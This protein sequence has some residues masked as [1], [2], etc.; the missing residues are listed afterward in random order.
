M[1]ASGTGNVIDSVEGEKNAVPA[2]A[3]VRADRAH[4]DVGICDTLHRR[5]RSDGRPLRQIVAFCDVKHGED[6]EEAN[7]P[8]ALVSCDAFTVRK[9]AQSA[10]IYSRRERALFF[11]IAARLL[12][13]VDEVHAS[14]SPVDLSLHARHR[15]NETLCLL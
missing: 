10:L 3:D 12:C 1:N 15:S 4:E 8:D 2:V 14:E 6:L 13:P 5:E 7:S 9:L 11:A